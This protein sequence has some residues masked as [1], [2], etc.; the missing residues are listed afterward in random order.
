[1]GQYFQFAILDDTKKNVRCSL[2][3]HYLDYGSKITEHSIFGSE[4]V[5]AAMRFIGKDGPFYKSSVVWVGDYSKEED[6]YNLYSSAYAMRRNTETNYHDVIHGTRKYK[7]L[8]NFSK[9]QYVE[10]PDYSE[11]DSD[12]HIIHYHPLPMLTET[13][14]EQGGGGTYQGSDEHD[15]LG[16]WAFDVLGA[17]DEVPKGYEKI[18]YDFTK[19]Y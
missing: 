12:N 5:D 13:G 10:V 2:N 1:M 16:T 18:E 6:D 9:K 17:S 15:L 19:I 14:N 4:Y 7:Y 8:V 3:P 11:Y